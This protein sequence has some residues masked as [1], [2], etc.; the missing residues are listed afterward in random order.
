MFEDL[1]YIIV[2]GIIGLVS[3]RKYGCLTA[4]AVAVIVFLVIAKIAALFY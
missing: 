2:Y 3:E 4:I 1:F